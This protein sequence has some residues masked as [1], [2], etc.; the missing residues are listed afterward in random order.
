MAKLTETKYTLT[1]ESGKKYKF[2]IYSMDTKFSAVGGIY[3]F[4]KRI[5]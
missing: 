4:T 5:K 1:G 2:E 3:V